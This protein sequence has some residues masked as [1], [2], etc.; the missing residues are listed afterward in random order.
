MMRMLEPF[1]FII[2]RPPPKVATTP[3]VG[4]TILLADTTGTWH[5]RIV[6]RAWHHINAGAWH[7]VYLDTNTLHESVECACVVRRD[8]VT[9]QLVAQPRGEHAS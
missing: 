4:E 3:L 2:K 6:A 5:R 8:P 7:V 1:G 9:M